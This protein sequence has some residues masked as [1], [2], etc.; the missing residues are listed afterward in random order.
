MMLLKSTVGDIRVIEV[1]VLYARLRTYCKY[2]Q[3]MNWN[4]RIVSDQNVLLGKP[5]IKGTRISVEFILEKLA[6]GW[7]EEK[8]LESYPHLKKQDIQ[9]VFAYIN[10]CVKD[11]LLWILEIILLNEISCKLKFT[12][13]KYKFFEELPSRYYFNSRTIF[14]HK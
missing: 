14:W 5:V 11:G 13:S 3:D 8:I 2:F 7:N 4:E 10:D 12:C 1:I 9:A 6:D